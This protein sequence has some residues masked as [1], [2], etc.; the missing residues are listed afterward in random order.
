M[1]RYIKCASFATQ[2][3]VRDYEAADKIEDMDIIDRLSSDELAA[4]LN[5]LRDYA[6]GQVPVS[7]LSTVRYL[8]LHDPSK[9]ISIL[10]SS[11]FNWEDVYYAMK[12]ARQFLRDDKYVKELIRLVVD[13]YDEFADYELR[14][15][16]STQDAIAYA[17]PVS[18]I[19]NL[20]VS[21]WVADY[22]NRTGK[23]VDG[24]I[25]RAIHYDDYRD[26][27][28][29]CSNRTDERRLAS[30]REDIV[31]AIQDYPGDV[32]DEQTREGRYVQRLMT[33]VEDRMH[34]ELVPNVQGGAGGA[35]DI[36]DADGNELA[37]VDYSDFNNDAIMA[38]ISAD[39]N[40][41]FKSNYKDMLRRIIKK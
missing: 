32:L 22:L 31:D 15:L 36:Y 11:Q 2:Q 12:Q 23:D 1:K 30:D 34:L 20:D 4:V 41:E 5:D 7:V 10:A 29:R 40:K 13:H 21:E 27:I 35:I 26:S 9:L 39:S 24:R 8:A 37:S 38:F 14:T 28:Q 17:Y 19:D 33:Q 25:L 3:F 18:K 6:D 16:L